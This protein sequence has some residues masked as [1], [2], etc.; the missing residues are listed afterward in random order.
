MVFMQHGL[1]V[2]V[3][4]MS[5]SIVSLWFWVSGTVARIGRIKM[6][7]CVL[8]LLVT[9][10]FTRSTGAIALLLIG[11][12]ALLVTTKF[13]RGIIITCLIVTPILYI[14]TRATGVWNGYNL[15]IFIAEHIS[16]ERAVS[17][18]FRMDNE[19]I[20][21]EKALKH[22][23]FGWGGWGR[24]RVHDDEGKD[25]SV[26]DGLW[27]IVFGL[28]GLVGLA[29]L[30]MAILLPIYG[31]L[32]RYPPGTWGHPTVAS[33]AALSVLLGLYMIDNLLNAMINPIF[34][35]AAGGLT[36]LMAVPDQS[37]T[38]PYPA[39]MQDTAGPEFEPRFL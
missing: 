23:I 25:I 22:P 36:G 13:K 35:I 38:A 11:I 14:G 28:R 31:F 3:W 24:S 21:V 34:T 16:Y 2:G 9:T 7:W 26:T 12:V 4:M 37:E 17:L 32:R 8:A 19:N 30:N 18:W 5:A 29:A 1:M 33:G 39:P 6:I 15:Q 20:L 27:I 10:L